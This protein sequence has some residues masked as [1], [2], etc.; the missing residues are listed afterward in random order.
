MIPDRLLSIVSGKGGVGKTSIATALSMAHAARGHATLLIADGGDQAQ[1][2][3]PATP[4][5]QQVEQRLWLASIDAHRSLKEYLRRRTALGAV[6]TRLVDNPAVKRFLDAL[7]AFDELM[8]L[9][10]LYDYCTGSASRFER[11]VFDA[12]STGHCKTLLR[13]PAAAVATLAGGPVLDAAGKVSGLLT[14]PARTQLLIVSLAEETPVAEALELEAFAR[15][16]AG[17]ACAPFIVNRVE[18]ALLAADDV[19]ALAASDNARARALAAAFA[20]LDGVSRVQQGHIR[21][22]EQTAAVVCIGEAAETTPGARH[23]VLRDVLSTL[24][25]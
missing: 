21:R 9:G 14:D 24:L 20:T 13:T 23:A 7:P 8:T 18:P 3:V 15:G 4:D 10:K 11:I 22:L 1:F 12:P 25:G 5:P 19:A 2:G 6:Y 16:E 17:M